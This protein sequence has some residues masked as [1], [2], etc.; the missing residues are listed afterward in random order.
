LSTIL[1]GDVP[2]LRQ[3]EVLI[4]IIGDVHHL[5]LEI[6]PRPEV[7][8]TYVAN[9]LGAPVFVVSASGNP[10]TLTAAIRERLRAMSPETPMFN[11]ST[12]EQLLAHSLEA[13]RFSV[14]LLTVFAGVAL[15]LAGIGLYGVVSYAIGLRTHEI[16]IR[17]ALGAHRA[18]VIRMVLGQGLRIVLAG[19]GIGLG[20]APAIGPVF[21][22]V[23]YGISSRD[24]IALLA[25]AGMLLAV[26]LMACYFPARRAAGLDPLAALRT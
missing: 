8:R 15:L 22:R 20:T 6:A 3:R 4:G 17:V 9:P 11:V 19:L 25:G 1:I 13:R 10:E 12:M 7:Y 23:V 5:G 14:L 18:A 24:P 16:G 2:E 26:A 21:A